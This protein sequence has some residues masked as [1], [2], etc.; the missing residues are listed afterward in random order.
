MITTL[1]LPHTQ[2]T[3]HRPQNG[4]SDTFI[5]RFTNFPRHAAR[6]QDLPTERQYRV[7]PDARQA[8]DATSIAARAAGNRHSAGVM[9][10]S[11][12]R[13]SCATQINAQQCT[14]TNNHHGIPPA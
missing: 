6:F 9:L 11:L 13:V 10:P 5:N 3:T 4:T 1:G 12:E 8:S 7:E 14:T 2:I